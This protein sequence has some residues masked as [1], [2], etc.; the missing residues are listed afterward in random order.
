[1]TSEFNRLRENLESTTAAATKTFALLRKPVTIH[2]RDKRLD[3]VLEELQGLVRGLHLEVD[4]EGRARPDML[5]RCDAEKRPLTAILDDW[6][7]RHG[8]GYVVV[9]DESNSHDGWVQIRVGRERGRPE[10][11]PLANLDVTIRVHG[12]D[13]ATFK[14][15]IAALPESEAKN[16]PQSLSNKYGGPVATKAPTAPQAQ[17]SSSK[18]GVQEEGLPPQTQQYIVYVDLVKPDDTIVPGNLAQ[19]KV[20]CQPETCLHW[21]WRTIHDTFDVGLW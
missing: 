6:R 18:S 10:G 4:P 15:H 13:A 16:I 12:R 17:Q 20:Q 3:E 11:R 2:C 1:V 8:L 5:V 7:E 9:S 21:L 14:G 19:V